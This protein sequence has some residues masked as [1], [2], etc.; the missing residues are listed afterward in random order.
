MELKIGNK[1]KFFVR[2]GVVGNRLA[3]QITGAA[4]PY[5]NEDEMFKEI[6]GGE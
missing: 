4:E 6:E 2:P 5:L 1:K 3:V